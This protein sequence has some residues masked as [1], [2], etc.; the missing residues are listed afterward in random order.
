[1]VAFL[2]GTFLRV[3]GCAN[4][5]QQQTLHELNALISCNTSKR[6]KSDLIGDTSLTSATPVPSTASSLLSVKKNQVSA[7]RLNLCFGLYTP[8]EQTASLPSSHRCFLTCF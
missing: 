2:T 6:H 3:Y 1:M 7:L 8:P 4:I 5:K